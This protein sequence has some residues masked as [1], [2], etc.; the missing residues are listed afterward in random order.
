MGKAKTTKKAKK[1][2]AKKGEEPLSITALEV[3]NVGYPD[4]RE[5]CEDGQGS[6]PR[7]RG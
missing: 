5:G 3:E 6:D 2:R 1:K 4:G 7:R